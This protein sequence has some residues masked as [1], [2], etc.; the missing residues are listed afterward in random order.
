[1]TKEEYYFPS[2]DGE[3]S[4]HGIRWLPDGKPTAVLQIVH[5]MV[6]YVGRYE[7]FAAFLC[8]NGFAV[9]GHDHVGHGLS[10]A[11]ESRLG[12]MKGLHPSDT[13][14]GD[15]YSNYLLGKKLWPELPFFILGHS[16]GS[17]MLRKFLSVKADS[18][19]GLSGAIVMGTGQ[20][21]LLTVNAGLF[22]V[23]VLKLFKGPDHRSPFIRDMT[24]SASYKR[25]D[26]CGK[27]YSRS[28]LSKNLPNVEKYYHDPFC[29]YLFS[30]NG[31]RG[32]IES[33]KFDAQQKNVEKMPK[34]LPVLLVSGAEDPVGALGEGVKKVYASFRKAGL[35]DVSMKLY[36]GDRHEILNELD[37]TEVYSDLLKW[38]VEHE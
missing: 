4:I 15:V 13:M 25:Y 1:M 38:M 12:L 35:S 16:M 19:Q 21:P 37:R 23:D 7:E 27:D 22:L 33:T 18:L 14:V 11:D 36:E 24:Y 2:A 10:A 20:E 26:C 28:W 31:Y 5:G 32:L 9:F 3:S 17:Y 30:L 29:T 34:E 8:E 6:E